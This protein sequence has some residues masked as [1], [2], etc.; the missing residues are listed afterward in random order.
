M[1]LHILDYS[2]AA[3]FAISGALA[4][5]RKSL[6]VLGVVVIAL[7]TA[8]GGGTIRDLLLDRHPVFWIKDPLYVVVIITAALLTIPYTR[9]TR[10]P[11]QTLQIADGLGLAFFSIAGAQVA[12][13]AGEP[14]LIV[15][16]M[17]TITGSFGGVLRDVLVNDIPMI[18]R[19]GNI[20][21]TAV[22][23]GATIYV[24]SVRFELAR[25]PATILGMTTI[26]A[27]RFGAIVWDWSLP[28][29]SYGDSP[30]P[31]RTRDDDGAGGKPG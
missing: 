24:L 2:G 20:Y 10:P 31:P 28:V 23:V 4:A 21:A 11:M 25:V 5:G 8:T 7:V 19:R 18:F 16:M 12:E 13:A 3:V 9:W 17:A 6:D 30:E 22:I 27:L 14:G 15:V 26:A 1:I 29:Y